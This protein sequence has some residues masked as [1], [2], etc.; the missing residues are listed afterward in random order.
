MLCFSMAN[1]WIVG[2]NSGHVLAKCMRCLFLPI[3]DT[4][5]LAKLLQKSANG[6]LSK[7]L[8]W[9]KEDICKADLDHIGPLCFAQRLAVHGLLQRMNHSK[10]FFETLSIIQRIRQINNKARWS[11]EIHLSSR[12]LCEV[13]NEVLGK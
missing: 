13:T 9:R 6:V 8:L 11:M 12:V 4:G 1:V 5:S 3:M 2:K 10:Q 7:Y